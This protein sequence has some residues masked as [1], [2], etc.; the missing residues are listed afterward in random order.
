ML[1]T[2][3]TREEAYIEAVCDE[4]YR[5]LLEDIMDRMSRM[6][7]LCVEEE[8]EYVE[9]DRNVCEDREGVDAGGYKCA[10]G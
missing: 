2:I 3:L 5:M 9:A 6:K 1:E 4:A 7:A 10:H 8:V